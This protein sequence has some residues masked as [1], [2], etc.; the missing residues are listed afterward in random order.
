METIQE[1]IS[2]QPQAQQSNQSFETQHPTSRT[3]QLL[4]LLVFGFASVVILSPFVAK[5]GFLGALAWVCGDVPCT[6]LNYVFVLIVLIS[7]FFTFSLPGVFL[8]SFLSR[9]WRLPI[10]FLGLASISILFTIVRNPEVILNLP[11]FIASYGLAYSLLLGET[12][13]LMLLIFI[14]S[15]IPILVSPLSKLSKLVKPLLI[16]EGLVFSLFVIISV[17]FPKLLIQAERGVSDIATGSPT[18]PPI[19]TLFYETFVELPD[20]SPDFNKPLL[21]SISSTGERKTYQLP[22]GCRILDI[23]DDKDTAT[24]VVRNQGSNNDA[25]YLLSLKNNTNEQLVLGKSFVVSDRDFILVKLAPNGKTIF[26]TDGDTNIRHQNYKPKIGK[27]DLATQEETIVIDPGLN[28]Q[29]S[30]VTVSRDGST[31]AFVQL[32]RNFAKSPKMLSRNIIAIDNSGQVIADIPI[33]WDCEKGLQFSFDYS[34]VFCWYDKTFYLL[35]LRSKEIS[36]LVVPST[37]SGIDYIS[38]ENGAMGKGKPVLYDKENTV[39]FHFEDS[40]RKMNFTDQKLETVYS[41]YIVAL[42]LNGR[43]GANRILEGSSYVTYIYDF[44]NNKKSKLL[45]QNEFIF[46]WIE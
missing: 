6:A 45:N 38:S 31:A 9:S 24:C 7:W 12:Q 26:F 21:Y 16:F 2:I 14:I 17:V 28:K 1:N 15:A 39:Y 20:R 30:D 23:A 4:K 33:T 27:L 37:G 32:E 46:D 34:K 22:E 8:Y 3:A 18:S 25:W 11:F 19:G 5:A 40:V 44:S 42:F 36:Q 41:Q 35:D 43:F 10:I 13:L 29:V